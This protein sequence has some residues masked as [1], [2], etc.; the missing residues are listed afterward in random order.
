M[1]VLVYLR[2]SELL[3]EKNVTTTDLARAIEERLGLRVSQRT[4]E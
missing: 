2:L 3:R 1:S 4:L